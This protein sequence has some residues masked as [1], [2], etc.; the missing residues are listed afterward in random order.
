M[1]RVTSSHLSVLLLLLSANALLSGCGVSRRTGP[2]GPIALYDYCVL[3]PNLSYEDYHMAETTLAPSCT[4]LSD[5][6]PKLKLPD[7]RQKACTVSI[8]WSRGFWSSSAWVDV[9]DYADGTPVLTS[10]VRRGML[11][12]GIKGDVSDVVRDV[13]AARAA[14]PARPPAAGNPAPARGH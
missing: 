4:V 12:M 13:A 5:D 9:K 11:Y 3:S 1:Q 8:D 2:G 14:G 10:H 7:V 6:D